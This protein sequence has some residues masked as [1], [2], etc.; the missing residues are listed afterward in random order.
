M[1]PSGEQAFA[2]G[3]EA[4]AEE[5]GGEK[6]FLSGQGGEGR[7]GGLFAVKLLCR[8]REPLGTEWGTV[9]KK[10]KERNTTEVL[11]LAQLER[12]QKG[13]KEEGGGA[14]AAPNHL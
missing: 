6:V 11:F 14:K 7:G 3:R 9:R 2:T 13:L 1:P 12:G 4:K 8:D 5:W 10:G